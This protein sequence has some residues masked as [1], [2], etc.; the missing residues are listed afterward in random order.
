MRR[1]LVGG[2][3]RDELLSLPVKDRDWVVVGATP[4]RMIAKG[5]ELKD[6]QFQVYVDS[7]G[8]EH[9]LARRETKTALGHRG[10]VLDFSPSITLEEDLRRRDLTIN[11]IARAED[12]TLIDPFDGV[13]DIGVRQLRHVSSAFDEDPLRVLRAA[14]FHAR[15]AGLGFVISD[16]TLKLMSSMVSNEMLT[17]L[18]A[19]RRWNETTRALVYDAPHV[20][21]DTLKACGGLGACWPHVRTDRQIAKFLEQ[22]PRLSGVRD[23]LDTRVAGLIAIS[24]IVTSSES[25]SFDDY[26]LGNCEKHTRRLVGMTLQV[27]EQAN[28][29]AQLASAKQLLR[30]LESIGA[31]RD[32]VTFRTAIDVVAACTQATTT[33]AI[34]TWLQA[35]SAAQRVDGKA[36]AAANPGRVKE[37]IAAARISAVA[38]SLGVLPIVGR[39]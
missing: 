9:A 6:E 16:E 27:L 13:A 1:Y 25:T 18:S 19:A 26:P 33:L 32:P 17:T 10:F 30:F 35:L 15:F 22:L 21:F 7:S 28:H 5:F 4:E 8:E 3:V 37:A 20:Y 38:D 29:V 34:N 24:A 12:G 11:A 39:S 23:S 14:R 2:A 36:L 31:L